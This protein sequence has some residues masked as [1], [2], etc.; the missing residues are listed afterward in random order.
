MEAF[1]KSQKKDIFK[2]S[3]DLYS[4]NDWMIPSRPCDEDVNIC[5]ENDA[6]MYAHGPKIYSA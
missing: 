6:N 2:M 3:L 4:K 1:L 5:E